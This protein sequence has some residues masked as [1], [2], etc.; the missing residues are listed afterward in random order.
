MAAK[1]TRLLRSIWRDPDFIAL[2]EASQRLYLLL[3]SQPDIS[4]C[5]VLPLLEMRWANMA[6]DTDA[7]SVRAALDPLTDGP[8]PFVM[9]DFGTLEVWVRSY[10]KVD[11]LYRVPN[12]RKA[13]DA[14]LDAVTSPL[15]RGH[16]GTVYRTLCGTHDP[17][18]TRS[19][20]PPQQPAASTYTNA[21]ASS[22][23]RDP[24]P[25]D[26][27]CDE[28]QAVI[29]CMVGL[30]LQQERDIR[31]PG[32]YAAALRK[33]LPIEHGAKIAELLGKFPGAPVSALASAT[34]TGDTRH[35]AGY[36]A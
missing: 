21:N 6:A 15:L 3:M 26:P 5:G 13:I 22:Q 27:P 12:G 24:S 34:L 9:V 17:T 20:R 31:N 33:E 35:L 28:V 1:Y 10:L 19:D 8:K 30:R 32:R 11:E 18:D 36:A 16:I 4:A 14:A 23:H 25:N 29:D 7:D 2:S